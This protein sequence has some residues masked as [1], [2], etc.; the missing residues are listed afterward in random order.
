MPEGWKDGQER[1]PPGFVGDPN[2]VPTCSYHDFLRE[3][4]PDDTAVGVASIGIGED[5]GY[6]SAK[7]HRLVQQW[8]V[9]SDPL[10][11]VEPPGG[12]P[13]ELGT[14]VLKLHPVVFNAAVRTGSDYGITVTSPNITEAVVTLTAKI[15]VWGVPA[16]PSH[17]RIRGK[18]L[19]EAQS[20]AS[21]KK[22]ARC[23]RRRVGEG[24]KKYMKRKGNR[25]IRQ[26]PA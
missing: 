24:K 5:V 10:Y 1:L 14:I 23:T 17:D 6:K 7:L 11:N 12:V 16:D 15:T 20:Y 13:V 2:A 19:A 21:K 8:D 25:Q 22:E 18:C 3:K 9:V 26:A 4:C